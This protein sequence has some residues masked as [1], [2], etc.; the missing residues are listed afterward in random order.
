MTSNDDDDDDVHQIFSRRYR[1]KRQSFR[2]ECCHLCNSKDIRLPFAFF[3][4]SYA[5]SR[6]ILY[7][8]FLYVEILSNESKQPNRGLC[9][10]LIHI[11]IIKT[12]KSARF[13]FN[14][15]EKF[16]LAPQSDNSYYKA[17]QSS[18]LDNDVFTNIYVSTYLR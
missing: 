12:Y 8:F 13:A 18:L 16:H 7:T 14:L 3:S 1:T 4:Y 10:E 17:A 6:S 9:C 5:Q 15:K 2:I 11:I